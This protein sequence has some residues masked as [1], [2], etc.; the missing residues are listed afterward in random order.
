MRCL[1]VLILIIWSYG[2]SHQAYQTN[3][4][5]QANTGQALPIAYHLFNYQTVDITSEQELFSLST[6]QQQQFLAYYNK[7]LAQGED[8]HQIIS[9]YLLNKVANFT[10]Y[11]ETYTASQAMNSLQGNCMSLAILTTA[12]ARLVDVDLAFR[13]VLTLPVFEKQNNLVFS[14]I[15]V[16]TKLFAAPSQG[17]LSA[18]FSN[19]GV[20]ID[21]FPASSNIKSRYLTYH[22]FVAMYYKN[23]A[24]DALVVGD[25]ERAF[26]N[27]ITAYQ[28]DDTSVEVM[29]LLAVIHR[30]QGDER[31][32]EQIYDFAMKLAPNNLSLL[33][34]YATLLAM[35]HRGEEANGLQAKMAKLED[36]N[37]YSWLNQAYLAQQQGNYRQA[38]EFF[39]RTI[40]LAPYV[41]EAYIGLYQ[42][43]MA[44]GQETRAKNVIA[45]ALDWTYKP[46]ER[47][48]LKYKLY[49]RNTLPDKVDISQ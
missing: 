25:L 26:A 30:R 6:E 37:P 16:Q 23:I 44:K 38:I 40:E 41:N 20:V 36:P 2:C 15:H 49:G 7:A 13:E 35:Q 8:K 28:Y 9:D 17:G 29:N 43:Y 47:R 33:S 39:N 45:K 24:S 34:N 10:Y 32:A 46:S 11:G 12:L 21:Y 42:V 31:T 48:Q 19:A 3:Q 1:I 14:S 5:S 18:I 27:A 4:A 22:Q